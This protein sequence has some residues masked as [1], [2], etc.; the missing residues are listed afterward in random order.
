MYALLQTFLISSKV[1]LFFTIL[2]LSI[3]LK[4][5]KNGLC[6]IIE[7]LF[8]NSSSLRSSILILSINISP[9]LLSKYLN[10]K[11]NIVLL[12]LP[13]LPTI[14]IFLCGYIFNDKPL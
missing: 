12:P 14:A 6:L 1:T 13:L 9:S 4:L 2:K 10:N 5:N 8:L 3:I 11:L 7:I